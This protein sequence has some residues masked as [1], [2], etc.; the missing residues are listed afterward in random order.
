[1]IPVKDTVKMY[2]LRKIGKNVPHSKLTYFIDEIEGLKESDD[3]VVC[4][5]IRPV[6]HTLVDAI[7][8]DLHQRWGSDAQIYWNERGVVVIANNGYVSEFKLDGTTIHTGH[9]I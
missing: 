3:E 9:I 4:V 5:D 1:M 7:V 6:E 2:A 8:K